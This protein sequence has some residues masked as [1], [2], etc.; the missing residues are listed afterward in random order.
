MRG[1]LLSLC[2][3]INTLVIVVVIV[4]VAKLTLL[5][6]SPAQQLP[7]LPS[8]FASRLLPPSSFLTLFSFICPTLSQLLR[9]ARLL[10][11][12]NHRLQFDVYKRKRCQPRIPLSFA[13]FP[14]V[15]NVQE[16]VYFAFLLIIINVYIV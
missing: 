1:H 6:S 9:P 5:S 7:P 14:Q 8:I 16:N 15:I 2:K 11:R 3:I 4:V 12:C 10:L 13:Q